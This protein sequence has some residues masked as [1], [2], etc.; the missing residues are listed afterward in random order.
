MLC[1]IETGADSSLSKKCCDKGSHYAEL[2]RSV[3]CM[4]CSHSYM[5]HVTFS[6]SL[7]LTLLH[8]L[9]FYNL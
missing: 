2:F 9:L 4:L 7:K 1:G 8:N 6:L 5:K 3:H